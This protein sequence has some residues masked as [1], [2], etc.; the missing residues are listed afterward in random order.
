MIV[1]QIGTFSFLS[2]SKKYESKA[3]GGIQGYISDLV[4]YILI[5]KHKVIFIG[6]IYYFKSKDNLKYLEIQQEITTTYKFLVSLFFK[7]LFIR[8]PK[9]TIIHGHRPDHLIAFSFFRSNPTVL[10]IH[11]QQAVTVNIRKGY[12]IRKIYSCLENLA[13]K[14][15]SVILA[16]DTITQK[17]YKEHYPFYS[18]K[19][20]VQPTGVNLKLFKPI[21]KI[22][23]RKKFNIPENT[24]LFLYLGRVESPKRVCDIV[25]AFSLF[26]ESETRARL[27]I[28]GDGTELSNIK[29]LIQ[30]RRLQNDVYV[31]GAIMREQL[32]EIIN[33]AD[34]S[35]LY[36]HNEGSPLSIKESL[37]CG[38]P[39][40]ANPVGDIP[41]V[42]VEGFNGFIFNGKD[43]CSL[44]K[45]LSRAIV[46]APKLKQNCIES[47]KKFSTDSIFSDVMDE[48]SKL[49]N[50]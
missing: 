33:C 49:I 16:T 34:V 25:D 17:Y 26:R 19:I 45:L 46:D 21:D 13:I 24:K 20:K 11:G 14:K 47:V 40:V 6:R 9:K 27:M 1:C 29:D 12:I 42:I 32:P 41:E 22:L 28:V 3:V 5:N 48:Y 23:C 35:I 15:A 2:N 4:D 44:A 8:L 37:A 31:M 7:S 43:N 39:V 18:H 38:V 36:S 10:T 30:R 50:E